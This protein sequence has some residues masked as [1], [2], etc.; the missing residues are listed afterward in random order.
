MYLGQADGECLPAMGTGYVSTEAGIASWELKRNL[1][2][3]CSCLIL[4]MGKLRARDVEQLLQILMEKPTYLSLL[5]CV[6]TTLFRR[7]ESCS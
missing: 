1:D 5:T 4:H 6:I 2:V 7:V 3:I